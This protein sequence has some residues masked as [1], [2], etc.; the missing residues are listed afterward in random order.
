MR[1]LVNLIAL[2]IVISF[3]HRWKLLVAALLILCLIAC[4]SYYIES[5]K[6]L[7]TCDIELSYS[8]KKNIP[9]DTITVVYWDYLLFGKGIIAKK[10]S[11][12]VA[13]GFTKYKILSNKKVNYRQ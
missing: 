9:K 3:W 7:Y 10:D 2:F 11:T 4:K 8:K 5:H 6:A 12:I 1:E 13:E